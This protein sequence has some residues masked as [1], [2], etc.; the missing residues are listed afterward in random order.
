MLTIANCFQNRCFPTLHHVSKR[1][2]LGLKG[3][4]WG[5][6]FTI[7]MRLQPQKPHPKLP[8]KLLSVVPAQPAKLLA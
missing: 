1:V 4:A 7:F 5:I 8:E 2:P 6:A 3:C